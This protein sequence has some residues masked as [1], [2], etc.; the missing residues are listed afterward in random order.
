V[1]IAI[2]DTGPGL[3]GKK[4]E[5]LASDTHNNGKGFGLFITYEILKHYG[6]YIEID[7]KKNVGTMITLFIPRE[8]A[9]KEL[10]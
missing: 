1:V 8:H 6:G 4:L 10:P 7:G 3:S 5:E 9:A 2:S